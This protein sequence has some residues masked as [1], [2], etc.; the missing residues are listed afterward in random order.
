[1]HL[2]I[3]IYKLR[4]YHESI[5]FKIRGL[6]VTVQYV[7]DTQQIIFDRNSNEAEVV[8][9]P[10]TKSIPNNYSASITILRTLISSGR[11]GM[12][13]QEGRGGS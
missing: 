2:C 5:C 9:R 6:A 12:L 3:Q 1:M 8:K 4:N 11:A 10:F 13:Q 7:C